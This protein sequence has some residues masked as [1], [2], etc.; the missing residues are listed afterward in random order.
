M[1][2][3]SQLSATIQQ[4]L[5]PMQEEVLGQLTDK[6]KLFVKI[7][8]LAKI[9]K[10]ISPEC[11]GSMGRPPHSR[12]CIAY[13]FVAK[14]VWNCTTTRCLL[15]RVQSDPRLR[16]LCGWESGGDIPGES[17]FSRAFD[18]FA[19]SAL[20]SRIHEAMVK[21]HCGEKLVGHISR[22]STPIDG[23]EKAVKKESKK[24]KPK[25]KRGRPKKG[26][27]V[28]PKPQR[29]VVLQLERS[30]DENA[31]DL[32]TACD[33][34][35]K[36]DSK[37]YKKTWRGYKLHVDCAD[38]DIPIS[39]MLTSASVH[40]SQVAIPLA[41]MSFERIDSCYDL[42]DAAYDVPEIR[43]HSQSL[44]HVPLID[45]NKRR[46]EKT[47]FAPHEKMRYRERS[48]AERVMSNIKD[49]FGGRFVRVRTAAKVMCHLMFGLVAMTAKQL[50]A[51]LE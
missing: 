31:E 32:P 45:S 2:I 6:H 15:D 41:Q 9:E 10:F 39:V 19:Q 51:Q 40:D 42:M 3:L 28:E 23:R 43:E 7:V 22:D 48:T 50:Y 25:R 30:L 11:R 38:G 33:Y 1:N 12:I 16:R 46:G 34:G 49:N 5:F 8:E 27:P 47:P 24:D 14:A 35:N 37:G 26:E 18:E 17:T 36:R 44:G 21:E 4:H 29:R 13:A 20:P